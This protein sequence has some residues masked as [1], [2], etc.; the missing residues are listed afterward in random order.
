MNFS[1]VRLAVKLWVA[2]GLMVT[3]LVV[4]IGFAAGRTAVDRAAN[5]EAIGVRIK[6]TQA[7]RVVFQ[8]AENYGRD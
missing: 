4:I 8:V 1:N 2:T 6:I 5:S 3:G 7:E